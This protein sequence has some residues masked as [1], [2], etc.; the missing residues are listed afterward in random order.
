MKEIILNI[1]LMVLG[2]I[3]LVIEFNFKFND[4]LGLSLTIGGVF[5]I[6][7][8]LIYNSGKP[9]KFLIELFVNFF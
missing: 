8:G 5:L 2:A 4:T 7:A 9:L 1:I 3:C 6:G